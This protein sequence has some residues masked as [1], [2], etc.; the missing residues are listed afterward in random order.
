MT[1]DETLK[2]ALEAAYLAGFNASGEGYNGE[3]PFQD[4]NA[5]PEQDADW[6]R[7][8]DNKIA[9]IEAHHGVMKGSQ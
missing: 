5:H 3:Y 1:K 8:R 6:V 2:L 9:A 4:H 7:C